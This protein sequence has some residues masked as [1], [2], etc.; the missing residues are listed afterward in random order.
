MYD[1]IVVG[2]GVTGLGAAY[3]L[4][5]NNFNTLLLEQVLN[6]RFDSQLH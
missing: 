6:M 1:V 3:D 5:K 2:A 4:V